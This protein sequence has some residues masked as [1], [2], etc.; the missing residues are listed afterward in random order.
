LRGGEQ[1]SAFERFPEMALEKR[2][3]LRDRGE[4]QTLIGLQHRVRMQRKRCR[5]GSRELD[6]GDARTLDKC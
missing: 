2:F 6:Y 5:G 3:G 4:W 1:S